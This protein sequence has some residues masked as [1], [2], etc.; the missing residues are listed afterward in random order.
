MCFTF[1][2][3]YKS[4]AAKSIHKA[5]TNAVLDV[6]FIGGLYDVTLSDNAGL[7]SGAGVTQG[8]IGNMY[9]LAESMTLGE[10]FK[11]EDMKKFTGAG[12]ST[13][14]IYQTF[15]WEDYHKWYYHKLYYYQ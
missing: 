5:L 4:A 15:N 7:F 11:A 3:W 1:P 10:E 9:R 6:F 2:K 13:W 8:L 12:R 14:E